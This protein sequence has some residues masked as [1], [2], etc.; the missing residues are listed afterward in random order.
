MSNAF[1]Y[2]KDDAT[3]GSGM[4]F[5]AVQ[6][7]FSR[8]LNKDQTLQKT[9]GGGVDLAGGGI[10]EFYDMVVRVRETEEDAA[11]ASSAELERLF[12]LNNPRGSPSNKL[13]LYSHKGQ[14][15]RIYLLGDYKESLL[16][17]MIEGTEAW[18]LIQLQ[19]IYLS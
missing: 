14:W 13:W 16:S 5:R 6:Q 15:H 3:S 7:G 4:R 11:Y 1:V 12:R 19:M 2:L 9:V 8:L 18:F 17:V 10:Y